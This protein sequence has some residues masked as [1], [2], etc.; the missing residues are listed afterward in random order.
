M[1]VR[2]HD[3]PGHKL[4]P[5]RSPEYPG[6]GDMLSLLFDIILPPEGFPVAFWTSSAGR[7]NP[8]DAWQNRCCHARNTRVL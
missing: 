5:V 8:T 1:L 4:K 3:L 7:Y 6:D 2:P